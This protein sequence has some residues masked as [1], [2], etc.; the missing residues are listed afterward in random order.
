MRYEIIKSNKKIDKKDIAVEYSEN[1]FEPEIYLDYKTP[2]SI[3]NDICIKFYLIE[4]S[5]LDSTLNNDENMIVLL[6]EEL[7]KIYTNDDNGYVLSDDFGQYAYFCVDDSE[8]NEK[9]NEIGIKIIKKTYFTY[10]YFGFNRVFSLV[11]NKIMV[12]SHYVCVVNILDNESINLEKYTK[13]NEMDMEKVIYDFL[14]EGINDVSF[15]KL[16]DNIKELLIIIE[17]KFGKINNMYNVQKEYIEEF[18]DFDSARTLI[19]NVE[20]KNIAINMGY[21]D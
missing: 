9:I 15:N 12:S 6:K 14:I 18:N 10:P 11:D 19:I 3:N 1:L 7:D 20:E 2:I 8:I 21:Y 17:R 16:Y 13:F 5:Y 4:S